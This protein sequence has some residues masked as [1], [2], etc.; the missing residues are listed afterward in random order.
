VG[1]SG[2]GRTAPPQ[3]AATIAGAVKGFATGV[4]WFYTPN[5]LPY[6]K[7]VTGITLADNAVKGARDDGAVGFFAGAVNTIN[8]LY[9]WGVGV[10]DTQQR[11]AAGD[12]EGAVQAATGVVLGIG[13]T[14]LGGVV[15]AGATRTAETPRAYS[16]AFQA[17]LDASQ[18]GLS[19]ARH[20]AIANDALAQARAAIPELADLVPAP[21]GRASPPPGWV[22]QHATVEQGRGQPGV[23]QLVPKPQH[24][25]GS[26]F[27]RILH[28][29]PNGGGGYTEW[30]IPAGAPPN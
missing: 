1:T 19:R 9:H 6:L 24:T 4:Y 10:V 13:T 16:V 29:L 26:P 22:W 5:P 11:A 27:W 7:A 18:F 15:G 8:P 12:T 23:L 2:G 28:P 3:P 21:A 25:G 14:V 30:A 17:E 20:F